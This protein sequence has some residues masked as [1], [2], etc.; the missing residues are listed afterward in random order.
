MAGDAALAAGP[1][2]GRKVDQH[3]LEPVVVERLLE[4]GPVVVVRK[5]I[6]DRGE[7]RG[8]G[9]GEAIHE[10]DFVEKHR[11]VGGESWHG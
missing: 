3:L 5:Q 11:E 10:S 4:R 1:V 7:S 9:R 8:R 2:A 6:F